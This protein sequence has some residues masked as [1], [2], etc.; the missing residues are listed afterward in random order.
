M[1]DLNTYD[2]PERARCALINVVVQKYPSN[3][4]VYVCITTC[5]TGVKQATM[6]VSDFRNLTHKKIAE[7]RSWPDE[8]PDIEQSKAL[9][10]CD[11]A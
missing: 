5:M 11:T 9:Q 3:N 1:L 6:P 7:H 2:I 8:Q 4:N 10:I